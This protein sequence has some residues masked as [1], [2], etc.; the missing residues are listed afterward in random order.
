MAVACAQ[1]PARV[2]TADTPP[3]LS[4]PE[5]PAVRA[6]GGPRAL[7]AERLPAP[8]GGFV[9]VAVDERGRVGMVA[10]GNLSQ[11]EGGT[12][13]DHALP[14]TRGRGVSEIGLLA[15]RTKTGT[16]WVRAADGSPN[17]GGL[18]IAADRLWM[19]V[20]GGVGR[21]R[22][23]DGSLWPPPTGPL[24]F[25]LVVGAESS[26]DESLA[27][28][29]PGWRGL[30]GLPVGHVHETV[31]LLLGTYSSGFDRIAA[32]MDRGPRWTLDIAPPRST[33]TA[34]EEAGFH[35][36]AVVDSEVVACLSAVGRSLRVGREPPIPL[37]GYEK[38][39]GGVV[40]W[41]SAETGRVMQSLLLRGR[42]SSEEPCAGFTAVRGGVVLAEERAVRFVPRSGGPSTVLLPLT[43]RRLV[44]I[45]GDGGDQVIVAAVGEDKRT[46]LTV[47]DTAR[48]RIRWQH[49]LG[50]GVAVHS[51]A[52]HGDVVALGGRRL[53]ELDLESLHLPEPSGGDDG[54]VIALELP[55]WPP[56]P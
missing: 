50:A 41:V 27:V 7:W 18:T 8:N 3:R 40:L 47:I 28:D 13:M 15:L 19:G 31:F 37:V 49:E 45:A 29:R 11:S 20:L 25:A 2:P 35:G 34:T 30:I 44:W 54:F 12:F 4:A 51:V 55:P 24:P 5:L 36:A 10:S 14:L 16:G 17:H 32:W 43:D 1:K 9:S 48:E 56:V 53:F 52:I 38:R 42:A 39:F 22:W 33:A 6:L 26:Q 46:T 23:P 21:L